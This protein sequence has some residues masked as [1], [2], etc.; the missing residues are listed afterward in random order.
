MLGLLELGCMYCVFIVVDTI[1]FSSIVSS[2]DL[3]IFDL[4]VATGRTA[5]LRTLEEEVS[6]TTLV[7]RSN[8]DWLSV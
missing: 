1:M 4:A 2:N 7:Q 3:W 5:I 6:D 8:Q